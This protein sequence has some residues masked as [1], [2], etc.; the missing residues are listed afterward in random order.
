VFYNRYTPA[1]ENENAAAKV[2]A[3]AK[4]ATEAAIKLAAPKS[5]G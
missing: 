5:L 2:A 4:A 3:K 1:K